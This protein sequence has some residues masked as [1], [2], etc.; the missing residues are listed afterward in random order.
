MVKRLTWATL[1]SLGL[2][3]S[4]CGSNMKTPD[5]T[6]NPHPTQR[7]EIT[8]TIHGAPRGFDEATGYMQYAIGNSTACTPRRPISGVYETM[9]QHPPITFTRVDDKTYKSTVVTDYYVDADY[10]GL[11]VCHWQMTAVVAMLKINGNTVELSPD[12]EAEDITA[13]KSVDQYFAI[14]EL[15]SENK[16][17]LVSPGIPLSSVK[18][19]SRNDFFY[20]TM[21]ARKVTP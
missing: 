18:P 6:Q 10:F 2:T 17:H 13:Q 19:E 11:G 12:I 16:L 21:A 4:A 5:I 1:L 3:T 7:Y 8:L 20:I 9:D 15:S 14:A